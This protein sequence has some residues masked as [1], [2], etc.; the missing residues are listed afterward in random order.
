MV[1]LQAISVGRSDLRAA[2]MRAGDRLR[3]MAVDQ[4]GVP[5]GR[6]EA[7]DLVGGV[8]QR[9]GAVDGDVVVVPEDDQ[10]VELEVAGERDRFLAD[11]FHQAAVAGQHIGVVVDE[12]VAELRRS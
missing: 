3:I 5:A 8:G 1:V 10:L 2:S 4:A 12:V 9:H 11:A 6:L 7:G